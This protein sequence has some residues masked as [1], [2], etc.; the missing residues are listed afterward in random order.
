VAALD[1]GLAALAGSK[2]RSAYSPRTQGLCDRLGYADCPVC[3]IYSGRL[4]RTSVR[5]WESRLARVRPELRADLMS[6]HAE[7]SIR[8]HLAA[9]EAARPAKTKGT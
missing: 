9:A 6:G 1:K 7:T 5:L 2:P 4:H 3:G 8:D